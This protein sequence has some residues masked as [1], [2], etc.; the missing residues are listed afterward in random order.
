M[1][2]MTRSRAFFLGGIIGIIFSATTVEI[3]FPPLWQKVLFFPGFVVGGLFYRWFPE[4]L[5]L[6]IYL[7]I[8]TVGVSYGLVA[9]GIWLIF[10]NFNHSPKISQ[11]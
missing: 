7:G 6:A 5:N 10:R 11:K 1:I 3:L 8:L 2:K 9:L 4:A